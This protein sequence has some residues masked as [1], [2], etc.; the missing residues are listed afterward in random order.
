MR[1]T[2]GS[3]DRAV[4]WTSGGEN[5]A[6]GGA[7]R[8]RS[9]RGTVQMEGV[10]ENLCAGDFQKEA[11][12]IIVRNRSGQP[13]EHRSRKERNVRSIVD[14]SAGAKQFSHVPDAISL[15]HYAGS[16][17]SPRRADFEG[18]V[19][20]NGMPARDLGLLLL[21]LYALA[22]RT[23]IGE[24]ENSFFLLLADHLSFDAGWTGVATHT[25][26][27]PVMHNSFTYQ[28]AAEFFPSWTRVRDHDPLAQAT[29][30]SY[31]HA[32]ALSIVE[33]GI[34]ARFRD[35]AVKCGL[36]QLMCVCTLDHRFGLTT[37]LSVYRRA[38]DKPFTKEDARRIEDVIPHLAAALTINRSFQLTRERADGVSVPGRALCDRFGTVH[39]GDVGFFAIL[40]SEWPDCEHGSL[41]HALVRHLRNDARRA[42]AGKSIVIRCV[43]VAGLFQL[44]AQP[45]S[46]L[47]RLSPRELIAIRLF[48]EG[49]S[50][51]EVAQ[52]MAIAPTTV[53][54]YLRCAY[55]KLEMHNKS[56]I[57][58]LLGLG[59]HG[60][61]SLSETD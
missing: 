61:G 42:Y 7:A 43:P 33:P 27:G 28:L 18:P 24:F 15:D 1:Q 17:M 41:P 32:I 47:D 3:A 10:Q 20:A 51:K 13:D 9:A 8:R 54:H 60:N 30:Q 50:H 55:K 23:G 22:S 29:S 26:D 45:R 37:F 58:R 38:L 4:A 25:S 6:R 11:L 39:Q 2:L 46:P 21:D 48:G 59:M 53:R 57:Q 31:G 35:W 52:R 34:D 40:R 56:Q 5:S 44:D 49:L 12:V 16:S 19:A 14:Q 36:A